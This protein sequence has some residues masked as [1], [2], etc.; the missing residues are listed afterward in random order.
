M[1]N[2]ECRYC[3]EKFICPEPADLCFQ[4]QI[5][6]D[7]CFWYVEAGRYGF[8]LVLAIAAAILTITFYKLVQ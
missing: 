1:H 5:T 6:C 7:E 3:K 8:A 2:H 4:A